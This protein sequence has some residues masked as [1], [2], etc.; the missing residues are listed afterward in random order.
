MFKNV[1]YIYIL[2]ALSCLCSATKIVLTNDDGWAVAQIR[3]EYTALK[4]AGYEVILSAPAENK[5]GTGSSTAT[6]ATLTEPCEFNTCPTGSPP[7]GSNSSDPNINYVNAFPVDAVRFGIQTLSPRIFGS[8]PD[9]VISGS[10][11]GNNLGSAVLISGT[12]GAASEAALEGIPS[13]AF[14]GASGSQVP[15]PLRL[16]RANIYTALVLKFTAVLLDNPTP[17]LPSG[18]S[19]NVNFA[20]VSSCTSA[21][22]YKFVLTRISSSSTPNVNMCGSSTLPT[23]SSAITQGCIATVSVF[24]GST[25]SDSN[26]TVQAVVLN[27]LSSLLE[28]P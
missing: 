17:F 1:I 12:V 24:N 4:A 10:N 19:L 8:L 6:P 18:V 26:S 3:A 21:S 15:L 13:I 5:S 11:I 14:S 22:D 27:K 28:C 9:I 2:S 25:K 23:E 20:S 7:T 16:L